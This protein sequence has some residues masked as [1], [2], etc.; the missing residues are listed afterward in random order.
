MVILVDG[1]GGGASRTVLGCLTP[2]AARSAAALTV[3]CG[4][5]DE[6]VDAG[7][8]SDATPRLTCAGAGDAQNPKIGGKCR[9]G[10]V[11]LG[12]WNRVGI[13]TSAQGFMRYSGL[14]IQI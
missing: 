6:A 10:T 1:L 13:H 12:G 8:T 3:C 2:S 11:A 5:S 14:R 9:C 4:G 7:G